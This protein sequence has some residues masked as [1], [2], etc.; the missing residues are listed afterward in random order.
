M[1]IK[2]NG[3]T[4]GNLA[5]ELTKVIGAVAWSEWGDA[6]EESEESVEV[7]RL[8][9]AMTNEVYQI[10]WKNPKSSGAEDRKVVVRVYG[11]GV[12]VF[13]NRDDEIRTFEWLSKLG[14]GPRLL[15]QF[16]HGRVEEFIHART[17]SATDLRDSKISALIASKLREFHNLEMPA[18]KNVVLW[19]RMRYWL[20]E[21][22]RLSSPIDVEEFWLETLEE[23]INMLQREL[24]KDSQLIGFCHNDLQYGNIMMDQHTS[25]ITLIQITILRLPIFWTTLHTQI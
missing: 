7:R 20:S 16:S 8:T 13:F 6:M 25:S 5:E 17:L 22:K 24:S 19:D 12:E 9:G 1:A 10:K 11:E 23:E 15:A 18:P 2:W 21:A 3:I 4:K 14:H